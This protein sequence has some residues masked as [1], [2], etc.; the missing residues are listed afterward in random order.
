MARRSRQRPITPALQL[1]L[2]RSIG[3]SGS[4]RH[5]ALDAIGGLT[6][7][8]S[9]IT[10]AVRIKYRLGRAPWVNV[11]KPELLPLDDGTPIPHVY[12]NPLRLCLYLPRARE[13]SPSDK[14]TETIVPWAN[15]WLMYYEAWRTTGK[16]LG[17]GVHPRARRRTRRAG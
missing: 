12:L 2:L 17:G 4:V 5:G 16:W 8:A 14:L 6:P 3:F 15:E 7:T 13:W 1:E 11:E 9:S 10:Y